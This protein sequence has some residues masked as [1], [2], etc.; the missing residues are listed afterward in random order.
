MWTSS[1]HPPYAGNIVFFKT[2]KR[3]KIDELVI[4][5]NSDLSWFVTFNCQF[6]YKGTAP[7]K[8]HLLENMNTF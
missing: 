3:K 6:N 5:G 2:G 4:D 8:R 1:L 7:V